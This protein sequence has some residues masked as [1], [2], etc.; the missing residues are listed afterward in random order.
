MRNRFVPWIATLAA[1]SL[2]GC[3]IVWAQADEDD[4]DDEPAAATSADPNP[5]FPWPA[6]FSVEGQSFTV[7][8]PEL[9]RWDGD[10]LQGRA[11]IAVQ[12]D[13]DAKPTYGLAELTARVR[14]DAATQLA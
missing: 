8:P 7:Y 3:G 14:V 13:D 11:A 10:Q 6:Q 5:R 2:L 1:V 4:D 12:A 9:E